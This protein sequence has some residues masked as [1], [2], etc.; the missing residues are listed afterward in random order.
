MN[1]NSEASASAQMGTVTI[2]LT[3]HISSRACKPR[4]QEEKSAVALRQ[5][6][7]FKF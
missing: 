5:K 3:A 2:R 7:N 4:I 6:R 1:F